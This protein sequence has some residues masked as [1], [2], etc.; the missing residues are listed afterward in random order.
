MKELQMS[1]M[2]KH[3]FLCSKQYL[4]DLPIETKYTEGIFIQGGF[5]ILGGP[6][7]CCIMW[8]LPC[9]GIFFS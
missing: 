3:F 8:S 2:Q 6:L 4:E 5:K 1:I 9:D 7:S